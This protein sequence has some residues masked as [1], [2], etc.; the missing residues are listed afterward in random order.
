MTLPRPLT[1]SLDPGHG[2]VDGGAPAATGHPEAAFVWPVA[3]ATAAVLTQAG[4]TV[5]V[6]RDQFEG[7]SMPERLARIAQHRADV[8]VSLHANSAETC[9]SWDRAQVYHFTTSP[10]GHHLATTLLASLAEHTLPAESTPRPETFDVLRFTRPPAALVELGFL[11]SK[12]GAER[13]EDPDVQ[14]RAGLAVAE[15]VVRWWRA[16]K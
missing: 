13:L 3:I 8:V 1:V 4:A 11:C 16:Q 6:T 15:G 9:P 14:R 2:G 10:R 12:E 5:H 7:L